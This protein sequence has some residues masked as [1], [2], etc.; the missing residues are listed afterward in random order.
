MN[1]TRTKLQ[2]A[3]AVELAKAGLTQSELAMR[4]GWAP[5]TLSGWLRN[6][7]RP[8]PNLSSLVENALGIPR[9]SLERTD[10]TNR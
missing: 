4:A 6:V 1:N 8:P 3:L 5:S 2:A 7:G 9:G 10:N